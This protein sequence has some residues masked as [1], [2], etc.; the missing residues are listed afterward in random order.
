MWYLFS[1]ISLSR[2][3]LGVMSLCGNCLAILPHPGP[4]YLN[5]ISLCVVA[6]ELYFITP[7]LSVLRLFVSVIIISSLFPTVM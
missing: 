6:L 3:Y 7:D 5:V 2:S 4:V 1:S